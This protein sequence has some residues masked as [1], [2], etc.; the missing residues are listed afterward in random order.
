MNLGTVHGTFLILFRPSYG[1]AHFVAHWLHLVI[2]I[3]R[4]CLLSHFIKQITTANEIEVE[5]L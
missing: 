4:D 2:L 5:Q 3:C 1:F